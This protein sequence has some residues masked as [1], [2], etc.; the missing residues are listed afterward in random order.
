MEIDEATA[1]A[2]LALG[3]YG[4]PDDAPITFVKHRENHV[5]RADA[6]GASYAVRVHRSGY[7]SEGEIRTELEYVRAL[8]DAGVPV[9]EVLATLDGS[10][11]A[12]ITSGDRM[13]LVSLQRWLVD[14]VPF[15]DIDAA[16]AGTH[17]P[18][19]AE[20]EEIG[21]MLARLHVTTARIGVPDGFER[22]A[23]DADGLAGRAPL[24][25]DPRAL[26]ALDGDARALLDM[27]VPALHDRLRRLGTD[28]AR[29]G[30]V[31]ADATPENILRCG[32]GFVL[33]DFDDFG[34][35]WFVFD[36][37]TALFHHTGHPRAAEYERALLAGYEAI[38]PLSDA[39][40]SSWDA[41]DLAR[42][43]SYLGWAAE[44]PHDPASAFIAGTVA[45]IV[46]RAAA[47]FVAGDRAPWRAADARHPEGTPG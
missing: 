4:L 14:A 17:A 9:P 6:P 38:R 13:H 12:R 1:V 2:R 25:G 27:A 34:T 21:A 29:Y 35:G 40:R 7:H 10:P 23:W 18:E 37:V 11:F 26:R 42:G 33:I 47:A 20:F 41:L 31:H 44:R 30:V 45:P 43:L 28:P 36:L 46:L 39:E 19:P 3:A 5:F 24:W 32:D 16:L 8:R 22:A 15:G